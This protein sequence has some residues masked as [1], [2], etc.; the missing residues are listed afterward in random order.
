MNNYKKYL[1]IKVKIILKR[2]IANNKY[3]ELI[4]CT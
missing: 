4:M 2:K 3:N 1:T